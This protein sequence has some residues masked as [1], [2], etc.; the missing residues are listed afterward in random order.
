VASA[1]DGEADGD[2]EPLLA[3]HAASVAKRRAQ[4]NGR[5]T[6]TSGRL[7]EN[8]RTLEPYIDGIEFVR[9]DA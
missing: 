1:C 8:A 5:T 9:T 6:A 7:P 4:A 2:V 3:P